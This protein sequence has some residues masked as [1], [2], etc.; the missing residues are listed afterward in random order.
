MGQGQVSVETR[1][2]HP[3]FATAGDTP[4]G[5]QTADGPSPPCSQRIFLPPPSNPRSFF[6]YPLSAKYPGSPGCRRLARTVRP[7]KRQALPNAISAGSRLASTPD[8]DQMS[9][10]PRAD[11]VGLGCNRAI[12]RQKNRVYSLACLFLDG[13]EENYGGPGTVLSTQRSPTGWRPGV[14][15]R[16]F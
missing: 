14:F 10:S 2:A 5:F 9:A 11:G 8:P 1:S 6:Q 12:R 15:R 3:V 16:V 13:K 7:Q 4:T